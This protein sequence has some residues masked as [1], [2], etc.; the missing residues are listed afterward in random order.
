MALMKLDSTKTDLAQ[1]SCIG[2]FQRD[3]YDKYQQ[4][5]INNKSPDKLV[6]NLPYILL[7]F[8]CAA[9]VTDAWSADTF[10]PL[11]LI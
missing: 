5:H 1:I 6:K 3:I 4:L 2:Y 10:S 8:L 9:P 7:A 11:L